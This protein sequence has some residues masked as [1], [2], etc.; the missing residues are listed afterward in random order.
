MRDMLSRMDG[1]NL[2]GAPKSSIIPKNFSVSKIDIGKADLDALRS[3]WNVPETHTVA[4][5]KSDIPGLEGLKFEGGS[6]KVRREAG[7]P[8]LD[9]TMPDREIRAPYDGTNP[10]H[11]QFIKHAEEGVISEFDLAVKKLGI[12]PNDLEGTL[13]IHQSNPRGVCSIC[14]QGLTNPN[15]EPGIFMKLTNKYPNLTIKV[16]TEVKDS[17]RVT[18]KQDFILK[19]GKIIE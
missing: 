15:K 7:L 1:I 9:E 8:D 13:Y 10:R 19:N 17:I 4:V 18:G 14:T 2:E 16:S 11:I 5:G 12:N 6:I 3:K